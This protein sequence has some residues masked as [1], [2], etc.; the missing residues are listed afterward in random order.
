MRDPYLQFGETAVAKGVVDIEALVQALNEQQRHRLIGEKVRPIGQI[1]IERGLIS[2][3]A[4][5]E[6]LAEMGVASVTG[7]C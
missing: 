7:L 6:V 1:L 3:D 4:V 2:R 5:Q